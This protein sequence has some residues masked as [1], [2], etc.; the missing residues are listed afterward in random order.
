MHH[1]YMRPSLAI[2]TGVVVLAFT[3]V[4]STDDTLIGF[5]AESS[6]AQ[7]ALEGRFDDQRAPD[8]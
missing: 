6:E 3:P 5:T 4:R 2:L 1:G 7:R 8:R